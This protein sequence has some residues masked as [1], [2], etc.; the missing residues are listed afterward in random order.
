MAM[1]DYTITYET[2]KP[3]SIDI[4]DQSMRYIR[5]ITKNVMLV[6]GRVKLIEVNITGTLVAKIHYEV[7]SEIFT[8]QYRSTVQTRGDGPSL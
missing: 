8:D 3:F 6:G 1:Q 5:E 4:L 7:P 2:D